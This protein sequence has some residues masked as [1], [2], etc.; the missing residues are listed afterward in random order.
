MKQERN[1]NPE[2]IHKMNIF[3]DKN[4]H[5]NFNLVKLHDYAR[6]EKKQI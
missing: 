1:Y 3:F 6:V 2:I 5:V 4:C